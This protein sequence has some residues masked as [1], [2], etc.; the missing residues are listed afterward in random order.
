MPS[1]LLNL[2]HAEVADN[3]LVAVDVNGTPVDPAQ[4]VPSIDPAQIVA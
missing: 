4:I 3:L 2:H 1:Y